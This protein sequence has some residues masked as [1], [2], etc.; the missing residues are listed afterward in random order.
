MARR[1][2][3]DTGSARIWRDYS[4]SILVGLLFIASIVLHTLFGWWQ[5]AAD[6]QG[7]GME[8]T[9]WGEDGYFV[10]WGE[11]TFQNWQSEFLVVVVLIVLSK[12]L[13]HKG[14]AES[15]DSE[16]EMRQALDRI[17][18]QLDGMTSD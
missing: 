6:Q 8:P 16:D 11:W 10:A 14:S 2:A 12:Y 7:H 1:S 4:L 13:I 9:L 18:R 5:Y 17:E 3:R 15:R